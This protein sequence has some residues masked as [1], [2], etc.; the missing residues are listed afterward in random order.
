[1]EISFSK[2]SFPFLNAECIFHFKMHEASNEDFSM[3]L[4]LASGWMSLVY[5]TQDVIDLCLLSIF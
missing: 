5:T 4:H 3:H 2:R 1:M